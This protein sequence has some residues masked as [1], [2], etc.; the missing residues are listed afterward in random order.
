MLHLDFSYTDVGGI[1]VHA[2]VGMWE[3]A[4]SVLSYSVGS[5]DGAP[6]IRCGSKC[7]Y[8]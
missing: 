6:F 7:L 3:G 1:A 8:I 4:L 2:V 5:G